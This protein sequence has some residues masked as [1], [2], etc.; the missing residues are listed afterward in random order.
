MSV[1]SRPTTQSS[2]VHVAGAFL[3]MGGWAV[4][5]NRMHAMPAPLVAGVVQGVLSGCI[6]YGL[7]RAIEA[8]ARRFEGIAALV[9]PPLVAA[10]VSLVALTT[11]HWL[12]RTPEIAATIAV[13]LT[14]STS[15]AA[16]YSLALWRAR[17]G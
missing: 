13:P 7:K 1:P 3:L 11:I 9:V 4:F 10:A 2:L 15:Y 14:V 17:K 16:L 12:S 6:T 5:A 8:L